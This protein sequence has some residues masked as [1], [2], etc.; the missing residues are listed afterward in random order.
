MK[1]DTMLYTVLFTFIICMIFVFF[2]ALANELTKD[3]VAFNRRHSERSAVL[4]AMGLPIEDPTQ[5]DA[6]YDKL[7]DTRGK[8]NAE[9]YHATQD[10]RDIFAKRFSGAGLWGTITGVIA[11][12]SAVD[13][14][15]GL[16]IVSHNETPG[17]GGRIDEP[18]FKNQFAGEI[19]KDKGISIR[20]GTGK[21]DKDTENGELDAV[22][23]ASRTSQSMEAIVNAEIVNLR[24]L[25]DEGDLK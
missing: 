21:G 15:V 16:S 25:R 7:V 8:G 18:W 10:G 2:L 6:Q 22:T 20:S 12:D 17:L 5:L 23:G 14:I 11:V 13:R 19:I 3:R 4:A 24:R 9:L 1:K